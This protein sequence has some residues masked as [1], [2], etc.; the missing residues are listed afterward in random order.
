[1]KTGGD[2]YF[3]M[4]EGVIQNRDVG[5]VELAPALLGLDANRNIPA[6]WGPHW[7]QDG[8][9]E[10][11]TLRMLLGFWH[12]TSVRADI[13]GL[14]TKRQSVEIHWRRIAA[15]L[16]RSA[17]W[18]GSSPPPHRIDR[19]VGIAHHGVDGVAYSRRSKWQSAPGPRVIALVR[20]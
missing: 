18:R 3:L 16:R 20:S 10:S 8:A 2:N 9:G 13:P 4:P 12:P 17:R 11:P 14:G 1:M 6:D 15:I 19:L 7:E 5:T